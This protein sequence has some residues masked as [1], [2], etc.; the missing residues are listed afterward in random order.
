MK[1]LVSDLMIVNKI[2][3]FL[4]NL[5]DEDADI[6]LFSSK[7][8]YDVDFVTSLCDVVFDEYILNA[9]LYNNENILKLYFSS[10][11]RIHKLILKL[12]KRFSIFDKKSKEFL[13]S[14]NE[15]IEGKIN[16][17]KDIDYREN[18]VK[19]DKQTLNE[20]EYHL[21]LGTN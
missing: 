21:L 6:E 2:V 20:E 12:K 7:I 10:L 13:D 19:Y 16:R 8:V 14:L 5:I 9:R 17:M 4:E 11:K 1:K 3:I 18:I 15:T